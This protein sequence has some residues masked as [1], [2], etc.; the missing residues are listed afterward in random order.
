MGEWGGGCLCDNSGGML[1]GSRAQRYSL[2]LSMEQKETLLCVN[3]LIN[4]YLKPNDYHFTKREKGDYLV[5]Y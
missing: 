3:V 4:I 1:L 2:S 5:Y